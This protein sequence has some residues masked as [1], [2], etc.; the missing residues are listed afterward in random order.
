MTCS[1]FI[2]S[3]FWQLISWKNPLCRFQI[4]FFRLKFG[5]KIP[6]RLIALGVHYLSVQLRCSWAW[7]CTCQSV[8]RYETLSDI[9]KSPDLAALWVHKDTKVSDILKSGDPPGLS[10]FLFLGKH[11]DK[12]HRTKKIE[13]KKIRG[14]GRVPTTQHQSESALEFHDGFFHGQQPHCSLPASR[15]PWNFRLAKMTLFL[16]LC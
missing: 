1:F 3:K 5:K 11:M 8:E 15:F 14:R 16:W 10:E 7:F 6:K 4:R 13:K 9:L 2:K 12:I